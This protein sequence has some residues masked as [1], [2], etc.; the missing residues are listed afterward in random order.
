MGAVGLAGAGVA[1]LQDSDPPAHT[2][3]RLRNPGSMTEALKFGALYVAVVAIS[4]E[5]LRLLGPQGLYVSSV[6]AGIAD[7]DAITLS[8]GR[9]VGDGLDQTIAARALTM[10][11]M[12]NTSLKLVMAAVVGGRPV[13]RAVALLLG[14]MVLA[15]GL[16]LLFL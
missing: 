13:G 16:A 7:V 10:A 11:S 4:G 12:T 9:M 8:V 2:D 5:A 6:L 15:G 14:P 3:D 1:F